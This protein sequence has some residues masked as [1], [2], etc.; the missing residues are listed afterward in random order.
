[1]YLAGRNAKTGELLTDT[2]SCSMCRRFIIN[3]GISKVVCRRGD[4][5]CTIDVNDWIV[6]DDSIQY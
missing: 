1:M 3:A 5:Y 4:D 2:T 6:D